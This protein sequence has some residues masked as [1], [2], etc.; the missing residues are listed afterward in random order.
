M[1]DLPSYSAFSLACHQG[2]ADDIV[3]ISIYLYIL[4]N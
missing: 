1:T 2:I 3:E 4:M